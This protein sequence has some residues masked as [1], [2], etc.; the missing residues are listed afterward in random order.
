MLAWRRSDGPG[1]DRHKGGE[2][3]GLGELV[4]GAARRGR[5]PWLIG[6]AEANPPARHVLHEGPKRGGGSRSGLPT[7][8]RKRTK[9]KGPGGNQD[10]S[11]GTVPT[12]RRKNT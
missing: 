8:R 4:T 11:A 1:T 3:R 7:P 5:T 12:R 6:S 10:W 9:L 2:R